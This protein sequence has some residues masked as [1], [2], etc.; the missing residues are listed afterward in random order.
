MNDEV[1]SP[2][3]TSLPSAVSQTPAA[4]SLSGPP[5][6][7]VV[8]SPTVGSIRVSKTSLPPYTVSMSPETGDCVEPTAATVPS[9]S[10]TTPQ[11]P[12]K[13]E[14]PQ[15]L[16]HSVFPVVLSTFTASASWSPEL[17]TS[18]PFIIEEF[19]LPAA[20][21]FP[22]VVMVV[23]RKLSRPVPPNRLLHC[24]SPLGFMAIIVASISPAAAV[25]KIP[26]APA[27]VIPDAY[28]IPELSTA[29]LCSLEPPSVPPYV[30]C[31][32]SV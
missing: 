3:I 5:N 21:I 29:A 32:A 9:L 10:G 19:D 7:V 22:S 23:A 30:L 20:M 31:H 26:V 17:N 27:P 12:S 25:L 15:V 11:N 18:V 28:K 6:V 13:P 14:P 4:P 2:T 1:V 8:P 16:N 24:N